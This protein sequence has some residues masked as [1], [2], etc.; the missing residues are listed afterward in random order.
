MS[1][2]D[3]YIIGSLAIL[4]VSGFIILSERLRA[5]TA[6]GDFI[7]AWKMFFKGF[8]GFDELEESEEG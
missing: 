7:D 5:H 6:S 8:D 1:E 3:Q 2:L 4:A